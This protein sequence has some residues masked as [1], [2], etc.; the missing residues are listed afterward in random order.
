[1]HRAPALYKVHMG[2][3]T[4][5]SACGPLQEGDMLDR[6]ERQVYLQEERLAALEAEQRKKR[7]IEE[8]EEK[9][10][11]EENPEDR[12]NI[13]DG[14]KTA[15][16]DQAMSARESSSGEEAA[17]SGD[18]YELNFEIFLS[19]MKARFLAGEDSRY[20]DYAAVDANT[21]LDEDWAV[22]ADQDA[23]ERYFDAD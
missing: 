22:I 10:E 21:N 6:L 9:E 7:Q 16:Q 18:Q 12:R 8:E 1:M 17:A 15:G 19:L 20:I 5:T 4:L 11:E 14:N 23:Q 13:G 2:E 3:T